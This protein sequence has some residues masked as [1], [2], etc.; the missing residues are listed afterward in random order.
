MTSSGEEKAWEILRG[1]DPSVVCRNASVAFDEKGGYYILRSFCTDF[2]IS[3]E[4][5]VIRSLTPIGETIITKYSYFFIH[6]CLWY[7]INVKDISLS[8][9]LIKPNN[10]KGGE[11]FFRGSHA[12]PLDN[13]AKIYG[14]DK[15]AFIEKGVELCAE[16]LNY[17]DASI[18][19][20]PVPRIPVILILWLK[21]EEFPS[22][23]DL[24]LD[25][26]CELQLPLDIIWSIAMMSVLVM[27]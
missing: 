27:M 8:G 7:L 19:L 5:R 21:D 24:L 6:S 14:D 1:L 4:E 26:T 2:S 13:V 10:I 20:L 3:P 17:G 11:M 9:K 18:N 15:E 22:R 16:V 23:A 12:L 25:S